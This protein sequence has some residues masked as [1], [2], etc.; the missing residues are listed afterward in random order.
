MDTNKVKP[1]IATSRVYPAEFGKH[2]SS[3]GK[4]REVAI[5]NSKIYGID[6]SLN[7]FLY[8]LKQMSCAN[9]A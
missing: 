5:G 1:P 9:F 8:F 6:C 2:P 4:L 7:N 3:T